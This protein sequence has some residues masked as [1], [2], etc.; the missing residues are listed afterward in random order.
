[1]KFVLLTA[2]DLLICLYSNDEGKLFRV[3]YLGTAQESSA[4][5]PFGS[6]VHLIFL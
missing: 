3:D 6:Q 4:S 5:M 1:M 2:G